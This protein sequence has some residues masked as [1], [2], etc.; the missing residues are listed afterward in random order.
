MDPVQFE[1]CWLIWQKMTNFCCTKFLSKSSNGRH[2][3]AYIY[4][5]FQS[6]PW[7]KIWPNEGK[8]TENASSNWINNWNKVAPTWILGNRATRTWFL[9]GIDSADINSIQYWYNGGKRLRHKKVVRK[10]I[11]HLSLSVCQ[12]SSKYCFYFDR[13]VLNKHD[14]KNEISQ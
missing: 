3:L 7:Y 5:K 12:L 8:G 13:A 4:D 6:N 2:G 11:F 1:L 14:K 9:E 10:Q